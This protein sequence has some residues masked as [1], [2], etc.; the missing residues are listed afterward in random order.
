MEI[1]RISCFRYRLKRTNAKNLGRSTM[2][3]IE[4]DRFRTALKNKKAE[5]ESANR[6][7][8]ALAVEAYSDE[9]DRLQHGQERDLAIGTLD[10][11]SKLLREVRI[12]LSRI[13]AGEFGICLDCEKEISM[14]RLA[15]VPWTASCIVCQEAADNMA[16]Q[17]WTVAAEP[18]VSAA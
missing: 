14:K 4:L 3:K 13:D 2:T 8:G 10:R 1:R 16:G 7:R 9:L 18:L 12:A 15:A 5:L 6:S 11:N 17:P